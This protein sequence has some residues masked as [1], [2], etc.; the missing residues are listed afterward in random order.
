MALTP[1]AFETLLVLARN[2]G[3]VVTKEEV[4]RTVWPGT[5]VEDGILAQNILTIRKVLSSPDWIETVPRR[6]YRFSV[7][8]TRPQVTKRRLPWRWIGVVGAVTFIAGVAVLRMDF[9]FMGAK[10]G[11]ADARIHSLAVLP[12]HTIPASRPTW[13]WDWLTC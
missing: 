2:P 5:F 7:P 1:K 3:R 13:P 6:G 4:M 11:A 12:F 9:R 10:S 8:V